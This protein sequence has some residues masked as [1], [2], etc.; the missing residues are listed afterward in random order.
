M[1][2]SQ[3]TDAFTPATV[4]N[5]ESRLVDEEWL[6]TKLCQMDLKDDVFNLAFIS[7]ILFNSGTGKVEV[8]P[9][10]PQYLKSI[11]MLWFDSLPTA[12][13][14]PTGPYI[15]H[16][17]HIFK[18]SIEFDRYEAFESSFIPVPS[19]LYY[20]TPSSEKPLS[21]CRLAIKEIYDLKGVRT[22]CSVRDFL[23]LY[24]PPEESAFAIRNFI[25]Y[26][27]VI[28]GKT[29]TT[30]FASGEGSMD[31]IDYQCPFNP[32]GDG[33]QDTSMSSAGSAAGLAAYDWI[34]SS[35][36]TDTFRSILWPASAH[37]LFG[38]RPT[39]KVLDNSGVLSLSEHLDTVGHFSRSVD[40]F[41]RLGDAWFN[42]T[43][44]HKFQL[45]K[46]ILFPS[47]FW[48]RYQTE[49]LASVVEDFV[50]DLEKALDV[51]RVDYNIESEWAS[52][53]LSPS[54]IPLKNYL[55]TVSGLS[56]LQVKLLTLQQTLSTIQLYD[57]YHNNAKFRDDF[58]IVN[59]HP[60]YVNPMIRFKWKL[61]A[62]ISRESYEEALQQKKIFHD[63][64]SSNIFG[65]D[66]I[67]LLPVG[68]PWPSYR[69]TYHGVYY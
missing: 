41:Y 27:A 49:Y 62:Q 2:K 3:A 34:D 57:C 42:G 46:R 32:R 38:L 30:Q 26:G 59:G 52:A 7:I 17:G 47:E 21:G 22:G 58:P 45:P 5:V 66:T 48:K 24:S 13:V 6:K 29:K 51:E 53:S 67:M 11:G 18:N 44:Q 40:S 8:T 25:A 61:G 60:P 56:F 43:P 68:A 9:D 65:P 50:Q 12:T 69:D 39:H 54:H 10:G 28:I 36:G 64:L 55:A 23:P 31:W 20:D 14:I 4:I 35:L 37:G 19:R 33:Y 63:F 1:I 16:L 15:W